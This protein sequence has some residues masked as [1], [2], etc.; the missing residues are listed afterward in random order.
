MKDT[1]GC[2][3]DAP[4]GV[5]VVDVFSSFNHVMFPAPDMNCALLKDKLTQ[6]LSL[7]LLGHAVCT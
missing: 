7:T 2:L 5:H 3:N 4:K 1:L 6:V